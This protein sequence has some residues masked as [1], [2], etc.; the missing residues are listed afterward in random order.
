MV[1]HV[2]LGCSHPLERSVGGWHV[3]TPIILPL[4]GS[5]LCWCFNGWLAFP[6]W[7]GSILIPFDWMVCFWDILYEEFDRIK[8]LAT[9]CLKK[10]QWIDVDFSCF[11]DILYEEF[12]KTKILN[13]DLL[14]EV[15]MD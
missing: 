7:D 13:H 10:K 6:D 3:S 8:F 11:W 1:E 4:C 5:A 12:V 2:E 15:T 14:V 9:I